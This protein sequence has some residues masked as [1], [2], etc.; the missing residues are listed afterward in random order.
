MPA[1][2][3]CANTSKAC[4]SLGF[5]RSPDTAPAFSLTKNSISF[6]GDAL[7]A[8]YFPRKVHRGPFLDLAPMPS[9]LRCEF[10]HAFDRL[11]LTAPEVS[12]SRVSFR[13]PSR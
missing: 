8:N 1:P 2:A 6:V 10:G 5:M 12:P 9:V 7:M 3:P 13:V 11:Q 4:A